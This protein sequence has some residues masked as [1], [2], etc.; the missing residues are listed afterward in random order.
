MIIEP[1]CV[2][3]VKAPARHRGEKFCLAFDLVAVRL[4]ACRVPAAWDFGVQVPG[5][6][7]QKAAWDGRSE[8]TKPSLDSIPESGSRCRGRRRSLTGLAGEQE[9]VAE[10]LFE[11]ALAKEVEP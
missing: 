7:R 9:S 5:S 11:S 4:S 1:R 10:D 8:R 6:A 3:G 2:A